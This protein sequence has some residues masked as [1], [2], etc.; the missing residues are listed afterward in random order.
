MYWTRESKYCKG[1]TLIEVLV[2]LTISAALMGITAASLKEYNRSSRNASALI[3]GFVK[4]AR[5]KGMSRTAAY[6][7]YPDA[8]GTR[9]L[10]SY[11]NRCSSTTFIPDSALILEMP[12]GTKL[13]TPTWNVCFNARGLAQ[14]NITIP[15]N[16]D[17]V[18]MKS[19]EVLL[20]GGTRE[21]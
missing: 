20:G 13:T 21:L 16:S 15:F 18:G 17:D 14:S 7:I 11:A 1:F 9:I 12:V 4:Q 3:Q 6:K 19:I 10:T 5:V 2:T 8:S